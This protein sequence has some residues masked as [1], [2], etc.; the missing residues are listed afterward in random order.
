M[1]IAAKHPVR[2]KFAGCS[3]CNTWSYYDSTYHGV[4]SFD[5][6]LEEY[7]LR[8]DLECPINF[9]DNEGRE[10]LHVLDENDNVVGC[11]LIS[12][13]RMSPNCYEFTGYLG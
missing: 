3:T 4:R 2:R 9:G 1:T 5:D 12:W 13:Y 10:Y 7:N 6:V 8:F 11:A